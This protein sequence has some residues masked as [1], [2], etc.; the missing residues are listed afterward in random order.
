M[1]LL[2]HQAVH[3]A[4]FLFLPK[5]SAVDG[6]SGTSGTC[7]EARGPIELTL[8]VERSD[9]ALKKQVSPGA[10]GQLACGSSVSSHNYLN[11]LIFLLDVRSQSTRI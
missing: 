11:F 6:H 5:L 4:E 1:K 9:G 2:L 7:F 10:P 8:G 3:M